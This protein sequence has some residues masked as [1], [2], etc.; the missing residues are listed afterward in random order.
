MIVFKKGPPGAVYKY[1]SFYDPANTV[2]IRLPDLPYER[3]FF[4][5]CKLG[6][7]TKV[8]LSGGKR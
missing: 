5:A 1:T 7:D 3:S 2:K 6:N 8:I 4:S